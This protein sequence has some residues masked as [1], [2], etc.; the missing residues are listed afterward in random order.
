MSEVWSGQMVFEAR[1]YQLPR[2]FVS[3]ERQYRWLYN[4]KLWWRLNTRPPLQRLIAFTTYLWMLPPL[5]LL[6]QIPKT[7]DKR[8]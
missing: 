7:K 5:L 4:C 3:V 8:C 2:V 1:H 6:T